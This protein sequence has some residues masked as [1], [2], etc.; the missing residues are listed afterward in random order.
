MEGMDAGE[1]RQWITIAGA[2]AA[3]VAWA[4]RLEGRVSL[5][6]DR[7]DKGDA[8]FEAHAARD[9]A[10]MKALNE[11]RVGQARLEEKLDR[12]GSG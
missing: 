2:F 1:L 12:N 3:L 7:L 10:I 8:R 6:S 11:L 5:N 9:D 4:V